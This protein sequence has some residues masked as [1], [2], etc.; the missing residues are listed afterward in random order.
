MFMYIVS[1]QQWPILRVIEKPK[2]VLVNGSAAVLTLKHG[3]TTLTEGEM[4]FFASEEYRR[5]YKVARNYQTRSLNVDS[6]SVF[7][8]GRLKEKGAGQ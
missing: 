4:S 5:F 2:G 3:E 7:F 6:N 8:F 1:M